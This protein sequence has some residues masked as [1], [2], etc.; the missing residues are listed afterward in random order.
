LSRKALKFSILTPS[1]G[2]GRF[3]G[4]C[5][6]SVLMQRDVDLEHVVMDAGSTDE[7]VQ[8]LVKFSGDPR[9]HWKSEPD[10]GQSHALTKAFRESNG[11][12]IGWLNADEFYLPG[13]LMSVAECI[14]RNPGADLVYG[15]YAEVDDLGRLRRMVAHHEYS[16]HVLRARCYI[17]SC[18]TFIRRTA[19]PARLWD[20]RC[21]SMMDWDLF[22]ELHNA[23]SQFKYSKH[24]L[25]AF[26]IHA[27]QVTSSAQAQS[28]EEFALIR[29]RHG[30]P[31]RGSTLKRV[32]MTGRGLR[33]VRK[34][35]EG[36]YVRELRAKRVAG[37][38]LR[39]FDEVD[40]KM[41]RS[42]NLPT[43]A[44]AAS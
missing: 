36:G 15:D 21:R 19:M 43:T 5:V 27:D 33:V 35:I 20:T 9:L 17:P 41:A 22:L 29:A 1:Y 40:P 2:Y 14:Q 6:R 39:W 32:E 8:E 23:G 38:N 28:A 25:A 34:V 42:L 12:W 18:A 7:T 11:D 24:T 30:I 44:M 10:E 31:L 16:S 3:V 37:M 26:R 4:D 13:A